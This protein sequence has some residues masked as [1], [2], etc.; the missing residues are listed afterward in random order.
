MLV[1]DGRDDQLG[2]RYGPTHASA[3]WAR[4]DL[5]YSIVYC[6][7]R[8]VGRSARLL[9]LS[10]TGSSHGF[11][12]AKHRETLAKHPRNSRNRAVKQA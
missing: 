7:G 12:F 3:R 5:Y 8:K 10:A 9:P 6:T 11:T 1:E 2:P 4:D